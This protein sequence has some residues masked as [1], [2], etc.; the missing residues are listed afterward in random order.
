MPHLTSKHVRLFLVDG[1]FGGIVTAEILN[2]TGHVLKGRRSQLST[3][4]KRDEAQRTGVYMLIGEENDKPL[5]YIGQ[6]DCVADRL[7]Q[8]NNDTSKGFWNEVVLITSKD[9]NL[10]SAH[11]RYL[12]AQ[13]CRRAK[14]LKRIRLKNGN[15]PTGGAGLPEA[16]KSDM[17]YFIQQ[18]LI[19]LPV[20]GIEFLRGRTPEDTYRDDQTTD[21]DNET[22]N[23]SPV[24]ELVVPKT[25]VAAKAQVIDGE[26]TVLTDSLIARGMSTREGSKAASSAAYDRLAVQFQQYRE[27]GTIRD[28]DHD[29]RLARLT[30]NVQ[31]SS[32]SAAA[33]FVQGHVTANGRTMWR[34]EDKRTYEAWESQ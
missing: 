26:F 19:L 29:D 21:D 9:S 33:A 14:E 32:P 31:F 3:I 28:D 15:D 11:V 2:W 12:E 1:T 20:L 6:T 7:R 16:D 25:G 18:I 5:A 34:T 10:T 13:L 22:S 4:C 17:D 8:H 30:R 27:D 24:F 23:D